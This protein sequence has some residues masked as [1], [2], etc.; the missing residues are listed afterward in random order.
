MPFED[1]HLKWIERLFEPR[2]PV[3]LCSECK[4]RIRHKALYCVH[5]GAWLEK[6]L[7][8]ASGYNWG[9]VTEH[10]ADL[11]TYPTTEYPSKV[12]ACLRL[13]TTGRKMQI[14][15]TGFAD[16]IASLSTEELQRVYGETFDL[17]PSCSLEIG[18]QLYPVNKEKQDEFA[19]W[20]RTELTSKNVKT[21]PYA[22]DHLISCLRALA[23][24]DSGRGEDFDSVLLPAVSK[25]VAAMHNSD[26]PF[27]NLLM[28]IEWMLT[29]R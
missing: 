3:R 17:T 23:R 1:A 13:L 7:W 6:S 4:T 14:F 8:T 16:R 15:M 28:T 29:P 9:L 26:N 12:Q 21:A 25:I 19:A 18:K 11:L 10:L 27:E 2:Q 20:V 5:C 24:M 22:S